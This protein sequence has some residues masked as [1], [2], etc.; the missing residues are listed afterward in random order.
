MEET[1]AVKRFWEDNK[2]AVMGTKTKATK[3]LIGRRRKKQNGARAEGED[4][5]RNNCFQTFRMI[6]APPRVRTSPHFLTVD[7][8]EKRM[9]FMIIFFFSFFFIL[10]VKGL[11]S[12]PLI[13]II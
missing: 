9:T 11:V 3:I 7:K 2:M 4:H 12:F 6:S 10:G 8:K 13:S 1:R 5:L